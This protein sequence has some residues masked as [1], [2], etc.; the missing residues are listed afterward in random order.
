MEESKQIGSQQSVLPMRSSEEIVK[1]ITL[2]KFNLSSSPQSW[3]WMLVLD[4]GVLLV[5]FEL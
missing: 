1:Y 5:N 2:I 3:S 4:D